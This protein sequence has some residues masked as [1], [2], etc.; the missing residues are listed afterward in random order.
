[1]NKKKTS[2]ET[3]NL[4]ESPSQSKEE[5]SEGMIDLVSG[6]EQENK[7]KLNLGRCA[8]GIKAQL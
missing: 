3:I 6:E 4:V 7:A 1:M 2:G 5:Q 8:K